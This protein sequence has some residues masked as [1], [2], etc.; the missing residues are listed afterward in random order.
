V[1]PGESAEIGGTAF[2]LLLIMFLGVSPGC[3]AE[4]TASLAGSLDTTRLVSQN[5]WGMAGVHAQFQARRSVR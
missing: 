2:R 4:R 1:K 3:F 5:A